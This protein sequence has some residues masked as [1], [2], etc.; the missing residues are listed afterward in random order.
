MSD[1]R[2]SNDNPER[3][4]FG[5]DFTPA[6]LGKHLGEGAVL[7]WLL[8]SAPG[9]K[10]SAFAEKIAAQCLDHVSS[11][12]D[13]RDMASHVITAM[14][15]YKL[16][17][18]ADDGT[19]ALTPI[20]QELHD[21]TDAERDLLFARHILTR[22]G[23]QRFLEAIQR[24]EL[25]G[26][27]PDL[28]AL[29]VE[30]GEAATSKNLSTLRA[31]LARS[32]VVSAKGAYRVDH[33]RLEKVLGPGV[34][35]YFGLSQ[36]ELEF[37]IAARLLQQQQQDPQQPLDAVAVADLA[38]SRGNTAIRRKSLGS[39]VK[40]LERRGHVDL[41]PVLPGKGGTRTAFR[42]SK[43]ALHISEAE[44]R[45][46]LAQ[47]QAGFDLSTLLPLHEVLDGL[48]D[49]TAEKI[50]RYGEQ[51]AV[52]LCLTLG[53]RV[54]GWR[55]RAPHAEIDLL[56]DRLSGLTYQR[57][58]VQVK[59]T[60]GD[61]DSDQVAREVGA[62]TGMG[63]THILFVVPRAD[64]TRP[65]TRE[66][67]LKSRLTPLHIYTLTASMLADRSAEAMLRHLRRQAQRLESEKRSESTAREQ[68][69]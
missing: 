47:S 43:P 20:G 32:G 33:E 52:H 16:L 50:G 5:Q 42:L 26:Q 15:S 30:L 25:R 29:S 35:E 13:R 46:L 11:D 64:I 66:V 12:K 10:K 61:L 60:T 31:W 9:L 21:A 53:L 18:V 69:S 4:P 34:S 55:K 44:L 17:E 48:H 3:L 45:D 67:L 19:V 62:T 56:A 63:V 58:A 49:G 40:R 2:A 57:W 68:L 1:P 27:V 14:R 51:L 6:T 37:L 36:L 22:C 59:N 28:E 39:F 38:D 65:A 7:S 8:Q 23:G 41:V 24:Y 54:Q